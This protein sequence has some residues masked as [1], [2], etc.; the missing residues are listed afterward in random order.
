MVGNQQVEISCVVPVYN[1]EQFLSRCVDSILDQSFENFELILI[2]D[3][4]T[5]SSWAICEKYAKK[6]NRVRTIRK[7]NQGVSAT[8]NCGLKNAAG[9]YICFID[10]DDWVEKDYLSILHQ[11]IVSFDGD[12]ARC[13]HVEHFP[14]RLENKHYLPESD[15]NGNLNRLMVDELPG[16]IWCRL[17]RRNF[18]LEN[19]IY[20]DESIGFGEDTIFVSRIYLATEKIV[21]VEDEL[22][23]YNRSNESS[24]I[25]KM[26][27]E[28]ERFF[29]ASNKALERLFSDHGL[30]DSLK[31]LNDRKAAR[32]CKAVANVSIKDFSKIF[33]LYEN[34]HS[35]YFRPPKWGNFKIFCYNHKWARP[36]LYGYKIL[37]EIVRK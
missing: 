3:G 27:I 4:S 20:F 19:D 10:C 13:N 22:Y 18:L 5:D 12:C 29:V 8:R 23:H 9:H 7:E 31:Y 15:R 2:D 11:S 1:G 26:N 30:Q 14:N 35:F 28:K 32:V 24:A 21:S 33:S 25:G 36:L 34:L 17:I 37:L 6:D 16:M